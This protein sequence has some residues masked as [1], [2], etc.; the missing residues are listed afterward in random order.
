M[1]ISFATTLVMVLSLGSF[2]A[3]RTTRE[4]GASADLLNSEG[5]SLGRIMLTQE[6]GGVHLRGHLSSLPAGPHAMHVHTVGECHAPDFKSAGAHFNPYNKK[7]GAQN[8]D[9]PHAGDLPNFTV[10]A[11]GSS[12][13]DCIASLVTLHRERTHSSR[14]VGPA[15]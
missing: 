2:I 13:I 3:F 8:K 10:R 9:G 1:N 4:E 14:P 15:W 11:D 5:K 12:D 6:A 7:H